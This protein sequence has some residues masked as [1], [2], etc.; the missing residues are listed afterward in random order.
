MLVSFM[1]AAQPAL[2]GDD[3]TFM[4][5]ETLAEGLIHNVVRIESTDGEHGF[6]L[7]VGADERKVYIVTAKHVISSDDQKPKPDA[8]VIKLCADPKSNRRIH[9][10]LLASYGPPDDVAFLS[11]PKP[12]KFALVTRAIAEEK[13]Q[14]LRDDAVA[15]G[16]N[17]LCALHA[18]DGRVSM[19]RDDSG[20]L[21]V[22]L[23]NGQGG[24]SG[25]PVLTGR[26][27]IGI[28]RNAS[29]TTLTLQ[30]IAYIRQLAGRSIPWDL[31]DSRNIP[32]TSPEAAHQ[33][34]TQ[35]LNNYLWHLRDVHRL[36]LMPKVDARLFTDFANS[37]NEAIKHYS[38]VKEK[39]DGTLSQYWVPGVLAD[40]QALR[41]DLWK[42]HQ[43]FWQMNSVTAQIWKTGITPE[44]VRADLV[45]LEPDVQ[46]LQ[47]SIEHFTSELGVRRKTNATAETN[48]PSPH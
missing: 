34:L 28:V 29:E 22:E 27:V 39:Y 23:P 37:Y 4:S 19:L 44:P 14:A 36:L 12:S 1:A 3:A 7:I 13:T 47:S 20:N 11:V 31:E 21:R 17:D 18:R 8:I 6:G 5:L 9:G 16:R 32:P 30:S 41:T 15:I 42:V 40:W 26:G 43:T 2:G 10:E 35:T 25:G 48:N 46:R 33:D 38:D 24:D 45:A